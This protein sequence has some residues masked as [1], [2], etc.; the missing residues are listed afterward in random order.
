MTE[1]VIH[2]I[3][4]VIYVIAIERFMRVFFKTNVLTFKMVFSYLFFYVA[5]ASSFLL[6][7][8]PIVSIIVNFTV[9]FIVTSN[10]SSSILKRIV[11]VIYVL[12]F[13]LMIELLL[14]LLFNLS[15]YSLL[16][17]V[18]QDTFLFIPSSIILLLFSL[19]LQVFK[20]IRVEYNL[21]PF[22][23]S[24]MLFLSFSSGFI[25]LLIF[26]TTNITP[27]SAMLFAVI[28]LAINVFALYFLDI[29]SKSYEEKL[30]LSLKEKEKEFYAFQCQ[31]MQTSAENLKSFRHDTKM[32][33]VMIKSFAEKSDNQSKSVVGYLDLLLETL[34]R[35]DIYSNTGNLV[36]DSIINY[37]LNITSCENITFN[38]DLSVPETLEL[39]A[40]DIVTILGNLLDNSLTAV[41]KL[42][43]KWI[44]VHIKFSKGSLHLK[45]ENPFNNEVLFDE[46]GKG[47]ILSTKEGDNHGYGLKN[48]RKSVEKYH[49]EM[50]I[51]TESN[52]FSVSI[53]LLTK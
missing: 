50:K 24:A 23:W 1:I 41:E 7:G 51:S 8:M 36:V 29:I 16:D 25:F 9:L 33:L 35:S 45:I 15:L 11:S 14:L 30:Q 40:C 34:E 49:G 5:S 19:S 48:V 4:N 31:I 37:K 20:N 2:L 21:P 10:Y 38:L 42:E 47:Y 13:M 28:L 27:I 44:N 32:H 39:E 12:L 22:V 46:S 18:Y 43:N 26:F 52:I 17:G 6:L 53:L 3:T